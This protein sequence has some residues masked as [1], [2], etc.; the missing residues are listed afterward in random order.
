MLVLVRGDHSVNEIKLANA[1]GAPSRP[2]RPEEIEARARAARLHR[3]GRVPAT[4]SRSCSTRR[5]ARSAGGYVTGANRPEEHLRGVVPGRD[6]AFRE[7][8]VRNVLEGD[9]VEGAR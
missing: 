3:P 5:A 4:A 8:D 7:V 6:F 9:T 2:A 1:L